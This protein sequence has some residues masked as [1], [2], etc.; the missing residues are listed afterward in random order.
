MAKLMLVVQYDGTDYAGFQWQPDVPTIQ[1]ELQRALET[2]LQEPTRIT[3]ASRTDA[4]VHA[5][6]QVVTF[7][8]EK[9]IPVSNLLRAVNDHLPVAVNVLSAPSAVAKAPISSATVSISSPPIFSV[10]T[11]DE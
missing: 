8:T 5:L 2:V 10:V 9:P 1:G 6:G 7:S 11:L 4:G 3:A